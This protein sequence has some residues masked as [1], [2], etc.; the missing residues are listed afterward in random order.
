MPTSKKAPTLVYQR[1]VKR[2][3]RIEVKSIVNGKSRVNE[4]SATTMR[5]AQRF[6]EDL[7]NDIG[8]GSWSHTSFFEY[9]IIR[10]AEVGNAVPRG[11]E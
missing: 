9:R 3:I 6:V 10:V 7:A 11:K 4:Y 1:A 5:E 2:P 8:H